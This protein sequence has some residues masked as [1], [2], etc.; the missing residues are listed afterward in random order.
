VPKFNLDTL[1]YLFIMTSNE[2]TTITLKGPDDWDAWDKQ[3]KAEAT[4]RSLIEHI[5]GNK[6]FLTAPTLPEPRSFQ[7]QIQTRSSSAG[8]GPSVTGASTRAISIADL[9]ADGRA[10]FQLALTYYKVEKD[11]YDR[12]RDE[13]DK[14]QTWMTKTVAPNYV[15][16]CFDYSEGISEWYGKLKEQVSINEHTIK[17]EIKASYR[18]AVKPLSKPPKDFE[19]WITTWEQVMA[20][21]INRNIPFAIDVDEWFDD[22]LNAIVSIK[23]SWVEAYRLTKAGEVE[24]GTLS[25]RTLANDF[26]KAVKLPGPI[27]R[28]SR[29]AKGSFG[30]T[31]AGHDAE[32]MADA[33]DP[34]T[35]QGKPE[36]RR[37]TEKQKRRRSRETSI[38]TG[39]V[40]CRAC[41][42][43]HDLHVCYYVFPSKAPDGF[44]EREAVR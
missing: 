22:F 20:K 11:L 23:P 8:P 24:N 30:P 28:T 15:Q 43:R 7:L 9:S 29:V 41:G 2:S 3:F 13:L 17:R 10:H 5:E 6:S 12:E 14:L 33:P 36:R 31:F 39:R 44:M 18:Q 16:T 25:Y 26:R 42:Q 40:V 21:G 37:R 32:A 1:L 4:R 38:S 34:S 35:E 19:A 27:A